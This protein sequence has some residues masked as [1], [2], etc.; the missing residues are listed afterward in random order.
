M[1]NNYILKVERGERIAIVG[2]SGAGKSTLL[3]ILGLFDSNFY[4]SYQLFDKDA[5]V[6]KRAKW[7]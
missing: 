2:E 1:L 4:G 7:L 5:V 6:L 3:N